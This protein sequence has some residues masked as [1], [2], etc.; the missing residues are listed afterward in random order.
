MRK[1]KAALLLTALA[2]VISTQAAARDN[3]KDDYNLPVV[4]Q[5]IR[6]AGYVCDTIDVIIPFAFSEGHHV[7]CN[8]FR[9]N[10]EIA[11]KGGRSVVTV[12]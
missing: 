11:N 7:N 6:A 4:K 8:G 2:L 9:Y 10:Y 12:K 3:Y 5:T 1:A